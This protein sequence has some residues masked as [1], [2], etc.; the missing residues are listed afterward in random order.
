[1]KP[2]EVLKQLYVAFAGGDGATLESLLGDTDWVEAKGGPYG[3]R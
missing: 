2:T 1:M 3:G